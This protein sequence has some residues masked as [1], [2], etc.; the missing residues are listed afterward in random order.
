MGGR[1][2]MYGRRRRTV[3]AYKEIEQR[4]AEEMQK[5]TSIGKERHDSGFS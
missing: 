4:M 2:P 1:T 5:G 3:S